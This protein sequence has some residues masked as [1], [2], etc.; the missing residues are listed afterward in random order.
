M[1]VELDGPRGRG[2]N[3]PPVFWPRSKTCSIKRLF[4][5]VV[6][7]LVAPRE[8]HYLIDMIDSWNDKMVYFHK[9]HDDKTV[10]LINGWP[11]GITSHGVLCCIVEVSE[12]SELEHCWAIALN[13]HGGISTE[14]GGIR[15]V[16]IRHVG[17][18]TPHCMPPLVFIS[19]AG[20]AHCLVFRDDLFWEN[21]L[22]PKVPSH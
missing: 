5:I 2:G 12:L 8:V 14:R 3:Y 22:M 11:Q 4:I 17:Q 13:N 19:A 1:P 15:R 7:N 6:E 18:P 20:S 9:Q 10:G 21:P 16:V